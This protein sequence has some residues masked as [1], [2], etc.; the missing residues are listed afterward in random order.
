MLARAIRKGVASAAIGTVVQLA[1]GGV[2][3]GLLATDPPPDEPAV[4][5][6]PTSTPSPPER[7]SLYVPPAQRWGG[8]P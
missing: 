3:K 6:T 4:V 1:T 2:L 7:H 5:V 8:R